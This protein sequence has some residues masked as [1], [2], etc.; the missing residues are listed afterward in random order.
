[1]RIDEI[2]ER[3]E[4]VRSSGR[5]W[6]AR[7]PAHEDRTPSLHIREGERG[8]LVKCFAGC[9][10]EEICA[11]LKVMVANL[12]FNDAVDPK[13]LRHQKRIRD[14]N[15]RKAQEVSI[16]VGLMTDRE[17]EA[18]RLIESARDIDISDWAETQ[19]DDALELLADAYETLEKERMVNEPTAL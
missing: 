9:T 19:L 3:L 18:Q 10:V 11:A 5:G 7:C 8:V 1:M 16:V 15:R 14:I 13:T 17:R 6:R 12:F 2:L 4:M